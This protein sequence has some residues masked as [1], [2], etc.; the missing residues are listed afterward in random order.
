[1][2]NLTNMLCNGLYWMRW[3]NF[4]PVG[5]PQPKPRLKLRWKYNP[6]SASLIVIGKHV[7]RW[8]Q[9]Q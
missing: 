5:R 1:M 4:T 9:M 7:V 6:E 2:R 3:R 8:Q